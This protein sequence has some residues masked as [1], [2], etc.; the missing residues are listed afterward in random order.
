MLAWLAAAVSLWLGARRHSGASARGYRW[1]AG[2]AGCTAPGSSSRRCSARR[3]APFGAVVRRPA[4]AAGRGGRRGRNLDAGHRRPRGRGRRPGHHSRGQRHSPRERRS[5]GDRRSPGADAASLE[6]PAA[7]VL[8]GLADGYVM[9]V[10][11]LVIGWVTLF[12]T[13]F[14]R[15]GERPG[16]FLLALIHPLAD[17]AVLGALLPMATAAWRRVTLPYLAVCAVGRRCPGRGPAGAGRG[18]RRRGPAAGGGRRAAARR[19]SV[20]VPAGE[21]DEPAAGR[22]APRAAARRPRPSSPR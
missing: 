11:L 18:H 7:P 17:L 8:P 14:H 15:S 21:P 16:T 1:L 12:S 19:G 5:P 3:T 20:A 10:A 6:G 22:A 9:A 4:L 13:E 2:A